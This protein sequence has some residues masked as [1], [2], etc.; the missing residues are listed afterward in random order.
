L[1]GTLLGPPGPIALLGPCVV[2]AP[3]EPLS[4]VAERC[5]PHVGGAILVAHPDIPCAPL[6]FEARAYGAAA[7]LRIER[8]VPTTSSDPVIFV[9]DDAELADRLQVPHLA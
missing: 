2:V 4:E 1:T 5:L 6:L 3:D 7:M 8:P 9:V